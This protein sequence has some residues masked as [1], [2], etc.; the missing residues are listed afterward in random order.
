MGQLFAP[1]PAVQELLTLKKF[2]VM[3]SLLS[4]LH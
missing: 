3:K 4:M 2:E 1:D